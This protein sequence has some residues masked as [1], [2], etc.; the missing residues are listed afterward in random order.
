MGVD[1]LDY[2]DQTALDDAINGSDIQLTLSEVL[3]SLVTEVLANSITGTGSNDTIIGTNGYDIISGQSG[4]DTLDGSLG[5]DQIFGEYGNDTLIGGEGDDILYAGPG[6]DTFI[7]NVGDG[8]DVIDYEN[9]TGTSEPGDV[10]K[11]VFGAGITAND[12]TFS[13]VNDK[14]VVIDIDTGTYTGQIYI[15]RQVNH[16]YYGTTYPGLTYIQ[17]SDSSTLYLSDID[18][19][20]AAPAE[21][22]QIQGVQSGGGENDTLIGSTATDYFAGYDGNDTYVIG[23]N[24]G[25]DNQITE[26]LSEGTDTI[27]FVDGITPD[28]LY[29]WTDSSG[30][31]HIQDVND[32]HNNILITG[33]LTSSGADMA[34]RIEYITFSDSTVWDLSAGMTLT[35]TEATDR[36]HGAGGNDVINGGA[37]YND[38]L[39]GYAGNDVLIGGAGTDYQGH[40]VWLRAPVTA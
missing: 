40:R 30:Y 22:G 12:L 24:F 19:T 9:W 25:N 27:S 32:P 33:A 8:W 29:I 26:E 36:I 2:A 13:R 14:D 5:N 28:D 4:D 6:N 35:G 38:Y 1:N 16:T 39:Y 20:Y 3:D 11:L 7:Y 34:Q 37:G 23:A 31:L 17:F 18:F 21:G 10:D 15:A